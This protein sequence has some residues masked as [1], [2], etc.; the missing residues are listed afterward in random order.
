[1]ASELHG[2][3]VALL[4]AEGV[5]HVDLTRTREV[6]RTAGAHV[7]LVS[8]SPNAIQSRLP[9]GT[10]GD[11]FR[12]NGVVADTNFGDVDALLL[13]GGPGSLALLRADTAAV[14]LVRALVRAHTPVA[15]I[16]H[17]PE[18]LAVADVVRDRTLTADPDVHPVIRRAGGNVID[19]PVTTDTG[20][21]TGRD[22]E[23]LPAFCAAIVEQF[24]P[25]E[26]RIRSWLRTT[27]TSHD[28]Q[29]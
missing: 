9:D 21:L 26:P 20:L 27:F 19:E 2:R 5:A 6:L 25:R 15:A 4:A 10:T 12:V 22:S 28:Q 8:V 11:P 29:A 24:T 1:M 18:I 3:R 13:P 7:R 23:S 16:G 17:G 14:G